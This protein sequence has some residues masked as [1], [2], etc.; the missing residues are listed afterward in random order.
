MTDL[1]LTNGNSCCSE[2]YFYITPRV[3]WKR[4]CV[5]THYVCA[6]HKCWL[7]VGCLSQY[8]QLDIVCKGNEYPLCDFRTS[9]LST[10]LWTSLSQKPPPKSSV[11]CTLLPYF[12]QWT[13]S[14][15]SFVTLPTLS[16]TSYEKK[17]NFHLPINNGNPSDTLIS[18]F[19]TP[20]LWENW[21]LL[22]DTSVFLLICC[23]HRKLIQLGHG[24]GSTCFNPWVILRHSQ[25]GN[26]WIREF[27][28][29]VP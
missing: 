4:I 18:N 28:K 26:P 29:H 13:D 7:E 17:T 19:Q 16:Y 20:E 27:W 1:L 6:T 2:E 10:Y 11:S 5:T 21:F 12:S 15:I 23:S 3:P 22:C 24:L 25:G 14:L 9:G 8:W